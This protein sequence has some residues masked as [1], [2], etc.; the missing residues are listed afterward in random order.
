MINQY[1][2]K[3]QE[4]MTNESTKNDKINIAITKLKMHWKIKIITL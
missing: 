1:K 2:R 4:K 3:V